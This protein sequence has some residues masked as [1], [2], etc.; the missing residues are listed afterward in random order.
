MCGSLT[1]TV[2]ATSQEPFLESDLPDDYRCAIAVY[3]IMPEPEDNPEPLPP[4]TLHR[5][6]TSIQ[7]E[8][9]CYFEVHDP[10]VDEIKQ[11][12]RYRIDRELA[13]GGMGIIFQAYDELLHRDVAIK[14]LQYQ[15]QDRPIFHQRFVNEALLTSRLQHPCIIPIYDCGTAPDQRPY[16]AMKLVS[17]ESLSHLLA[18]A[19]RHSV[20]RSTLLKTFEQVCQAVA[21]AHANGVL[22]LDLKPANVM[23]GEF[24]EV[25]L[26]DWGLA[27]TWPPHDMEPLATDGPPRNKGGDTMRSESDGIVGTA[28]YMSP[29]QARGEAVSPKTDVF[30]LGALLCEILTG[31]PP[32]RGPD[33]RRVYVRALQGR[34]DE[35][36]QRLD[37][38]DGDDDLV[39]LAKRCL[40]LSPDDRPEGAA[41]VA[42]SIGQYL[43]TALEQAESDLCRFFELTPDMFCIATLDGY[44]ERVNTNFPR[45]LGYNE[46]TLVSEPF[47]S[48]VHPDDV[49]QTQDVM[50]DLLQGKPVIRFCNRYRHAEG[51]YISLEWTAQSI[52]ENGT[53]FAVAREVQVARSQ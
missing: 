49:Q 50:R 53:I 1:S 27:R 5:D 52:P 30:G 13:R 20:D 7:G 15:F 24:G 45:V 17:G 9:D 39:A 21:Y 36:M 23:V 19:R 22:H 11:L 29:E 12:G 33:A 47:L 40:A 6:S 31:R 34:M 42:R 48:F 46:N 18:I 44:F 4:T 28:A 26:M 14:L 35:A 37:L 25:H 41:A 32:Y 8:D 38:C 2:L 10:R 16:F 43:E 51:H 3:R